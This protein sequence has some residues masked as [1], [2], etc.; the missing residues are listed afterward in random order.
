[1]N[2]LTYAALFAEAKAQFGDDPRLWN[3]YEVGRW[4]KQR[5][6]GFVEPERK[7]PEPAPLAYDEIG[8]WDKLGKL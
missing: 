7:T 2:G 5:V 8:R 4:M 1:M 6:E 3:S